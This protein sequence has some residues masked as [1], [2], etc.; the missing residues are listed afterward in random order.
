MRISQQMNLSKAKILLVLLFNCTKLSAFIS[1]KG[2]NPL[3]VPLMPYCSFIEPNELYPELLIPTLERATAPGVHI[4]L[5]TERG[6]MGGALSKNATHLL[7]LDRDPFVVMYNRLIIAMLVLANS[8]FEFYEM[9]TDL[10]YFKSVLEEDGPD[11]GLDSKTLLQYLEVLQ[12]ND[13]LKNPQLKT[14]RERTVYWMWRTDIERQE[15]RYWENSELFKKVKGMAEKG[16]IRAELLDFKKLE[17]VAQLAESLQ[18][19]QL[20]ISSIDFSNAYEKQYIG[21]ERIKEVVK[22]FGEALQEESLLIFTWVSRRAEYLGLKAHELEG[23][24]SLRE[25]RFL[26]PEALPLS[27]EEVSRIKRKLDHLIFPKEKTTL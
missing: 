10:L 18:E 4:F 14:K 19:S 15:V 1:F 2:A 3:R 13:T 12:S 27:L 22:T 6:F 26:P 23:I 11:K 24:P 17:E 7:G 8:K 21:F 16:H 9:R 5:G 20:K 25:E